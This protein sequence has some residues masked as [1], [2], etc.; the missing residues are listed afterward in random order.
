MQVKNHI[1]FTEVGRR[2]NNEDYILTD[3][4][5]KFDITVVCDGVGGAQKGEV[6]SELVCKEIATFLRSQDFINDEVLFASINHI[7]SCLDAYVQSNPY[8]D[9]M[10]TTLTMAIVDGDVVHVIHIGDSKIL[11]IQNG[12]LSYESYD[13]SLVNEMVETG[14]ISQAEALVHPK[15]NVITKALAAGMKAPEPTFFT[16]RDWN[17]GDAVFLCTDGVLE[18]FTVDELFGILNSHEDDQTIVNR[19]S[20]TCKTNSK[21]NSSGYLIRF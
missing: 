5:G 7:S 6:A 18:S 12:Q 1:G 8:S 10:A 3:Y 15:R 2:E 16:L 11:C 9:G 17:P 19:I 20:A 21:D 14:L 13:H 4:E